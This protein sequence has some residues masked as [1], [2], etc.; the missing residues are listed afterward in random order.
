MYNIAKN[1]I[2]CFNGL[3]GDADGGSG[4]GIQNAQAIVDMTTSVMDATGRLIN[5]L[6]GNN[7]SNDKNNSN[8]GDKNNNSLNNNTTT[9]P[10]NNYVNWSRNNTESKTDWLPWAFAGG[11]LLLLSFVLISN[12]RRR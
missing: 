11:A 3:S 4:N 8:N 2:D 7:S 9:D 1:E 12:N 5:N 6:N 10:A